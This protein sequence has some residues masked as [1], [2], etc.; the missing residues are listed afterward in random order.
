MQFKIGERIVKDS[1]LQE[2]LST[3]Q[4][5][6]KYKKAHNGDNQFTDKELVEIIKTEFETPIEQCE[7]GQSVPKTKGLSDKQVTLLVNKFKSRFPKQRRTISALWTDK[8]RATQVHFESKTPKEFTEQMRT[9]ALLSPGD[10]EAKGNQSK[11]TLSRAATAQKHDVSQV[12]KPIKPNSDFGIRI[13]VEDVHDYKDKQDHPSRVFVVPADF[14]HKNIQAREE[15]PISKNMIQEWACKHGMDYE[16][17]KGYFH[18]YI[19]QAGKGETY[20]NLPSDDLISGIGYRLVGDAGRRNHTKDRDD[21]FLIR[22]YANNGDLAETIEMLNAIPESQRTFVEKIIKNI[23]DGDLK[24]GTE[25]NLMLVIDSSSSMSAWGDMVQATASM[26]IQALRSMGINGQI[27][28]GVSSFE[29]HQ[30]KKELPLIAINNAKNL[31]R[32]IKEVGEIRYDGGTELVGKAIHKTIPVFN[33]HRGD[34]NHMFVLTDTDGRTFERGDIPEEKAIRQAKQSRGKVKTEIFTAEDIFSSHHNPYARPTGV[35]PSN[36]FSTFAQMP[37]GKEVLK[38]YITSQDPGERQAITTFL[39]SPNPP[40]SEELQIELIQEYVKTSNLAHP[41][42]GIYNC[43]RG[44]DPRSLIKQLAKIPEGAN[45]LKNTLKSPWSIKKHIFDVV[46]SHEHGLPENVHKSLLSDIQNMVTQEVRAA[47]SFSIT[48]QFLKYDRKKGLDLVRENIPQKPNPAQ[49]RAITELFLYYGETKDETWPINYLSHGQDI[50]LLTNIVKKF[51]SNQDHQHLS[52]LERIAYGEHQFN[53]SN[54]PNETQTV[55]YLRTLAMHDV[56]RPSRSG[57]SMVNHIINLHEEGPRDV[58][59]AAIS[60]LG[61][62]LKN[63]NTYSLKQNETEK[64]TE[65]LQDIFDDGDTKFNRR[66]TVA[67][68]L[69]KSPALSKEDKKDL[70]RDLIENKNVRTRNV[71]YKS[72]EYKK[73]DFTSAGHDLIKQLARQGGDAAR[74]VLGELRFSDDYTKAALSFLRSI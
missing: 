60:T 25:I 29:G 34:A 70:V 24:P 46:L 30:V 8:T 50:K 42:Q 33:R 48:W 71:Y 20:V 32:L 14:D 47:T 59:M 57:R 49:D 40:L 43:P 58:K 72:D 52:M 66:V 2:A 5:S 38:G 69:L 45:I 68:A 74:S 73:Y 10:T 23:T 62:M 31:Q 17:A 7:K 56:A 28:I 18:T 9:I 21:N 26:I 54:T 39:F 37:G 35:N 65:Q 19:T 4:Q 55:A 67:L 12:I 44:V 61:H 53:L 64:I 1:E 41:Q 36:F 13:T 51:I 22:A 6:E 15:F 3:I 27:R 16:S 11:V 63:P